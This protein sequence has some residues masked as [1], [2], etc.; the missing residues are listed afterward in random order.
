MGVGVPQG[1]FLVLSLLLHTSGCR[2]G[3]I[4]RAANMLSYITDGLRTHYDE[5]V[6]SKA[7]TLRFKWTKKLS[8]LG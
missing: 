2:H 6:P 7:R 5:W 1:Q 8:S 3:F 4:A